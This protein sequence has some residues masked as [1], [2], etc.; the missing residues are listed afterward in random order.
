[1]PLSRRDFGLLFPVLASAAQQTAPAQPQPAPPLTGKIYHSAQIPYTG[2]ADK[3]GR[4]FLL[5][6]THKG[7]QVEVHET[8]LGPGKETHPPHKHEHEELIVV[9]EGTFEVHLEDET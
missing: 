3:K 6:A 5:G 7:F 2:D 9:V 8:I 4:R 1:M